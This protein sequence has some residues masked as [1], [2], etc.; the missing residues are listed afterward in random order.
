MDKETLRDLLFQKYFQ[1]EKGILISD[2]TQKLSFLPETWK[3]LHILC[4]K[5]IK[6]FDFF[7]SLE[8]CKIIEQQLKKYFVLKLGMWKYVII[9][10]DKM[11][12]ISNSEFKTQFN[13]AFFINNFEEIKEE[14]EMIYSSLYHIERY[15][16]GVEELVNFYLENQDIL[17]LSTKLHY[18][19]NVDDAWTWFHIDFVKGN[20][21]VGFQTPDQFLYEQLFFKY[22]LTP[23]IMQDAQEKMGIQ[24]MQEIFKKIK[25]IKIPVEHI[26]SDL[27]QQYLIQCNTDVNK[28]MMKK[29]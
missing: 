26:P 9:D 12:N 18:K 3:K 6:H 24:K 16:G 7:S 20:V 8:K 27:Y 19:L 10:L 15:E 22:D 2:L 14:D 28:K 21:Q 5:N 4:E 13:E 11:Q 29:L 17:N 23:W 1:E 25:G